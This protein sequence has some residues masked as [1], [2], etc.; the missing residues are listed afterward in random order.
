MLGQMLGRVAVHAEH[1]MV[2]YH[3]PHLTLLGRQDLQ[4]EHCVHQG[5]ILP[6]GGCRRIAPPIIDEQVHGLE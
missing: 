5:V 2:E 6:S 4:S 3:P 1:I